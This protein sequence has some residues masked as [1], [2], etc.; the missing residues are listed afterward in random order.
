MMLE[1]NYIM[2][3]AAETLPAH[4]IFSPKNLAMQHE[5]STGVTFY[6][7]PDIRSFVKFFLRNSHFPPAQGT[8]IACHCKARDV[9]MSMILK[10]YNGYHFS[11]VFRI[12]KALMAIEFM[13]KYTYTMCEWKEEYS[14]C[15][16]DFPYSSI[17]NYLNEYPKPIRLFSGSVTQI[18]R[19]PQYLRAKSL[20]KKAEKRERKRTL[21]EREEVQSTDRS[22]SYM[23]I[24]SENDVHMDPYYRYLSREKA[25]KHFRLL[26][27]VCAYL[28]CKIHHNNRRAQ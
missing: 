9:G 5:I 21:T 19:N 10:Y 22:T 13:D 12:R 16:A 1:L 23:D 20:L 24:L 28:A 4:P 27:M 6:E 25:T 2:R 26:G 8:I 15:P 14:Q 18:Y 7:K 11:N 17:A 3:A